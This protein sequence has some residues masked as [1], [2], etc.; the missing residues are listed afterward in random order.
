MDFRFL[1]P[2]PIVHP[3]LPL[4]TIPTASNLL[5][6]VEGGDKTHGPDGAMFLPFIVLDL[7]V[8]IMVSTRFHVIVVVDHIV[9]LFLHSG[10]YDLWTGPRSAALSEY[11][12]CHRHTAPPRPGP[13]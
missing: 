12:E 10:K 3:P 4:H 7:D 8:S 5:F 13:I 6:K 11:G 2:R 9:S 1:I